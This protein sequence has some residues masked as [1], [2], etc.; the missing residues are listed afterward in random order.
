MEEGTLNLLTACLPVAIQDN[1]MH[2]KH[3][4]I[5][6]FTHRQLACLPCNSVRAT[7]N[8]SYM[9]TIYREISLDPKSPLADHLK[10]LRGDCFHRTAN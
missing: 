1:R 6:S 7:G 8:G 10:A 2:V 5:Y 3:D 9:S 4:W